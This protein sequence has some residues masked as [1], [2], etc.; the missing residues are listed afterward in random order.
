MRLV[1]EYVS[2][3]HP[4]RLADAI[5]ESIVDYVQ[6]K[7]KD[8]L[9]GLECAVHTNKVFIDGRIAAGRNNTIIDQEII[10]GIVK[11][12][13]REAG[14]GFNGFWHPFPD[15]LEIMFD[16]CIE[17]LSD[18]ER[19]LRKY[20]D[21]QN[22]VTGYAN[23]NTDTLNLPIEHYL[24][25][26][27]GRYIYERNKDK[28]LLGPDYKVLVQI[29]ELNNEYIWNRLTVSIEHDYKIHKDFSEIYLHVINIIK[30][31]LNTKLPKSLESLSNIDPNLIYVNGAGDFIQGGPYGDNGLSGKKLVVDFYGP[32]VPI[33]GGAICGKDQ[34]KIDYVGA[35]IAR[36]LA[37]DL[38]N[39]YN[40]KEV[41]TRIAWSPGE[42]EPYII[43]AYEVDTFGILRK[44]DDKYIPPKDYFSIESIINILDLNHTS[45]KD[46]LNK[47]YMFFDVYNK[48]QTRKQNIKR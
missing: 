5:V 45:K 23:N 24:S 16:L 32:R 26:L 4:D 46:K 44:I 17:R 13:Y 47:G 8:A 10:K 27:I 20:S 48:R 42:K 25:N 12:V 37:L 36:K 6:D 21:D 7:D 3:G 1:A 33:G 34:H 29:E 38:V 15:E 41:H 43:E 31:C 30:D 2:K 9:C 19:D 18:E 28:F 14:Y 39:D 35:L 11:D 22:V 40:Y